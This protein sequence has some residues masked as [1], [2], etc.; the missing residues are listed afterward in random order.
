MHKHLAALFLDVFILFPHL[1]HI[2]IKRINKVKTINA[3]GIK[4]SILP[5]IFISSHGIPAIPHIIKQISIIL[6][7]MLT[8]MQGNMI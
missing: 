1:K 7:I 3:N 6:H 8:M 5:P 4:K 2:K